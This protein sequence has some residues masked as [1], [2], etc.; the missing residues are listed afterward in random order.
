[1]WASGRSLRTLTGYKATAFLRFS[2]FAPNGRW[3]ASSG[4]DHLIRLWDLETG[5]CT[6]ALAVQY[7]SRDGDR[8]CTPGREW[9]Q[10]VLTWLQAVMIRP[11]KFG[12]TRLETA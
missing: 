4:E 1:M 12:I 7:Q 2:Q 9:V 8:F 10:R 6:R 3:L 5:E 11:S